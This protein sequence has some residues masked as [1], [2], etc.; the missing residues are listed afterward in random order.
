V[1]ASNLASGAPSEATAAPASPS[2]ALAL[3]TGALAEAPK[4]DGVSASKVQPPGAEGNS[5]AP[6]TQQVKQKF[7]AGES[8]LAA[9]QASLRGTNGTPDSYRASRL[10]W[11]AVGNGNSTAEVIL[12]DLYL[13]GDGVAR[14]C[15]QGRVLLRAASKSGNLEATEK[16][17]ELIK[18]GC[19]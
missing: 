5:T 6:H 1:P 10:L 8:E 3:P 11:A 2:N 19:Q 4:S 13:R 15:E 12:A 14:S 7:E 18:K 16:L 17:K 9:A